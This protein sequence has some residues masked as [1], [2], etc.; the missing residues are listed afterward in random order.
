MNT[1]HED[2][3][4]KITIKDDTHRTQL[5]STTK[6]KDVIKEK[7]SLSTQKTREKEK[8]GEKDYQGERNTNDK[9]EPKVTNNSQRVTHLEPPT[10]EGDDETTIVFTQNMNR[11]VRTVDNDL[12]ESNDQKQTN[13][14][15][16]TDNGTTQAYRHGRCHRCDKPVTTDNLNPTVALP[17]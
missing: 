4:M 3:T 1:D 10:Q 15:E 11:I 16:D 5:N 13:Q 7:E 12:P 17:C 14:R 6:E 2:P 9:Q 8:V